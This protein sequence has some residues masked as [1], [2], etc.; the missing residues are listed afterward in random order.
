[1][2]FIDSSSRLTEKLH[3]GECSMPMLVG[4]IALVV[5]VVGLSAYHVA[6]ALAGDPFTVMA[7]DGGSAAEA[8]LGESHEESAPEEP[9][10]VVVYVSGCVMSPGVYDF[11]DGTR[12]ATCIDAAGGFAEDA[13]RDALNLA[14]VVQD[15]EQLLVPSVGS[16]GTATADAAAS[17]SASSSS[18]AA[19]GLVNINT[20]SQAELESL[21]GVGASTAKKIIANR[22]EDG[23]F[24]T[25]EELKRVPGIGEKK[26][27]S[28]ADSIC[29]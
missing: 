14:R 20:A 17:S 1:M 21:S 5:L 6:N 26:Y 3:V 9:T 4:I 18:G 22:E 7:G 8:T 2:P 12:V 15:G 24:K 29:V 11:P 19:S 16:S 27:A 13:N 28:L 25:K 23:P 10:R